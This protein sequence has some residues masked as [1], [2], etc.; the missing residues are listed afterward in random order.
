MRTDIA[1]KFGLHRK[2]EEDMAE[3]RLKDEQDKAAALEATR[4]END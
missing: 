3:A 2:T 1:E 4:I